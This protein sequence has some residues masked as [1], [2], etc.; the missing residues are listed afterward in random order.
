[1]SHPPTAAMA[2]T[3]TLTKCHAYLQQRST[4]STL[5][6]NVGASSPVDPTNYS[7]SISVTC[8]REWGKFLLMPGIQVEPTHIHCSH[9]SANTDT[10]WL[11]TGMKCNSQWDKLREVW[12]VIIH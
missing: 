12:L 7:A 8:E 3:P 6:R 10:T 2:Q 1:M 9:Y 4:L 5:S 11:E